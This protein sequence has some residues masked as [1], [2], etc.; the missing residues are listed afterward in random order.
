MFYE[1]EGNS[2][3]ENNDPTMLLLD[4]TSAIAMGESFQGTKHTHHILC[5]CHCVWQSVQTK[6]VKVEWIPA[7]L[8]LADIA[9]RH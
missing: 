3:D 5:H 6:Q 4:N 1:L 9:I 8:Q 7:E 2:V